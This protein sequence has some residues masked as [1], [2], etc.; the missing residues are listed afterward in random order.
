MRVSYLLVLFTAFLLAGCS[1]TA[2]EPQATGT[3]AS[4]STAVPTPS[5]TPASVGPG[6]LSFFLGQEMSLAALGGARGG[7][8]GAVGRIYE[9]AQAAATELGIGT[10]PELPKTTGDTTGDTSAA[11]HFLLKTAGEPLADALTEKHDRKVADLF[12]MAVKGNIAFMLYTADPKDSMNKALADR[13]AELGAKTELPEELWKP[14]IDKMRAG[15]P[16]EEVQALLK[17]MEAKT[18]DYLMTQ[19]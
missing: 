11:L 5:H 14:A 2:T 17:E 18:R 9:K 3:P 8:P 16:K 6:A 4:P 13:L 19:S 1:Q 10:L 12:E 15:A 7:D